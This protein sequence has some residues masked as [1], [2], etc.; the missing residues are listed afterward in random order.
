MNTFNIM[1]LSN[2]SSFVFT[3]VNTIKI[4]LLTI[5]HKSNNYVIFYFPVKA[6]SKNITDLNYK[7]IK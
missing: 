7:L 6:Y 4:Y 2:I 1:N 3:F 5:Y